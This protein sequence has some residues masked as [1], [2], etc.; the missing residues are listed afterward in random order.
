MDEPNIKSKIINPIIKTNQIPRTKYIFV[1][2]LLKR[3]RPVS[4]VFVKAFDV[5]CRGFSPR[6]APS[7]SNRVNCEFEGS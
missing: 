4:L 1:R 2:I 3:L 7:S 5:S 6:P